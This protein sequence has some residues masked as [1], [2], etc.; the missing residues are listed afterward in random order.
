M[1]AAL[2]WIAIA[3]TVVGSVIQA[4]SAEQQAN[5]VAQQNNYQAAVASNNQQIAEGYAKAAEQ[6]GAV[7]AQQKQLETAQR[8]GDIKAAVG[9][10]GLVGGSGSALRLENDTLALG[11]LDTRTIRYNAAR[12]A[13]GYRVEGTSYAAQGQL[14]RQA[15]ENAAASG[16]LAEMGAVISGTSQV[17]DKWLR[18]KQVGIV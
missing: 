16:N 14:D 9:A 2:P 10:S 12:E 15:A 8:V 1:G 3:S 4:K 11:D 7:L 13:Y 17:S 5:A 18:Y 6:R